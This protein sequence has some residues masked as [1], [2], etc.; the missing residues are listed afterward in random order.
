[1]IDQPTDQS[2][3]PDLE[4][5]GVYLRVQAERHSGDLPSLLR[6]ADARRI[7][8]RMA[9]AASVAVV[10][11]ALGGAVAADHRNHT[12][13][14]T[15]RPASTAAPSTTTPWTVNDSVTISSPDVWALQIVYDPSVW[16]FSKLENQLGVGIPRG[17]IPTDFAGMASYKNQ[18]EV[19]VYWTGDAGHAHALASLAA[20][21]DL[22]GITSVAVA[23]PDTQAPQH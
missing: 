5:L 13:L 16:D 14:T 3:D 7:R 21:K 2:H 17:T 10:L 19:Q 4:M 1:M 18:P 11:L 15:S 22:A 12:S 9:T 23:Q 6:R 8:L 20:L